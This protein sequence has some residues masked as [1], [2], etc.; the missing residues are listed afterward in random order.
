MNLY[1]CLQVD[2]IVE[3]IQ[4]TIETIELPEKVDIIISEWMGYFLLRE[5]ML[6]S[7]LVARDKFLKPDGAL[8]PSHAR[9]LIAPIRTHVA[10]QRM[11]E[12]QVRPGGRRA[13]RLAC[14][15]AAGAGWGGWGWCA[16][17]RAAGGQA[18]AGGRAGRQAR[19][20]GRRAGR[21]AGRQAGGQAAMHCR[22]PT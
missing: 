7:V 5:S 18:G 6:D 21:Q 10:S 20:A 9:L 11:S 3:V 4:G 15:G 16:P 14:G 13:A 8:Y 22:P 19:R 17:G 1:V 12:L 2:H